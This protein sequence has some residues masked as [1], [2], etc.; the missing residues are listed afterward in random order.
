MLQLAIFEDAQR[1]RG[2]ENLMITWPVAIGGYKREYCH[3]TH[4]AIPR[5]L[6]CRGYYRICY[7]AGGR[8]AASGDNH[9]SSDSYF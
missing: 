3:N 5:L 1:G 7:V 8:R 2:A 9:Q 6:I 4:A